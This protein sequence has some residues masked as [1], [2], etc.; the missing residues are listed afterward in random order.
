[1]TRRALIAV[2]AMIVL[3]ACGGGTSTQIAP[4]GAA[5]TPRVLLE[6][7]Q[8]PGGPWTV[9]KDG[10]APWAGLEAALV[11]CG[12]RVIAPDESPARFRV[13]E[14]AAGVSITEVVVSGV[15]G[16][17]AFKRFY[18]ECGTVGK[19]EGAPGPT[20]IVTSDDKTEIAGFTD[21][22]LIVVSGPPGSEGLGQIAATAR[23]QVIK[24]G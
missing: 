21:D 15:D 22:H 7:A 24:A 20:N 5:P 11:P 16:M 6:A 23:E 19:V 14:S 8:L 9:T 1:M 3:S 13:F 12:Q 10:A 17:Q 4:T 2:A 18:A